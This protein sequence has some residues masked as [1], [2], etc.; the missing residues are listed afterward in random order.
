MDLVGAPAGVQTVTAAETLSSIFAA[1][2]ILLQHGYS[3]IVLGHEASANRGNL[4]WAATGE[5]VNHQWGK[6]QAAE[7]LLRAYVQKELVSDLGLFSLLMPIFDVVIFEL[8]RR[9]E[10]SLDHALVQRREAVVSALSQSAP[11]SG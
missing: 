5:E 4:I 9:D 2:P 8:L 6:S 11:T 10:A 7:R 1:L 3:H